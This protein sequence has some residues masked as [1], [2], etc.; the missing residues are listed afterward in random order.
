MKSIYRIISFVTNLGIAENTSPYEARRL[1][2]INWINFSLILLCLVI[3]LLYVSNILPIKSYSFYREALLIICAA[4]SMLCNRFQ[5]NKISKLLTAVYFGFFTLIFPLLFGIVDKESFFWFPFGAIIFSILPY[6]IFK[7][8]AELTSFLITI[9][10]YFL[11]TMYIDRLMISAAGG[12]LNMS[13]L[14]DDYMMYKAPHIFFWGFLNVALLV[15]TFAYDYTE[16]KLQNAYTLLEERSL[17]IKEQADEIGAQNEELIAQSDH[18]RETN[19]NLEKRVEER[20]KKLVEQNKMLSEYAFINAHLLR[21]PL[22]SVLGLIYLLSLINDEEERKEII[23]RLNDS[24]QKLDDV[25]KKIGEVLE[26]GSKLSRED[27]KEIRKE[28]LED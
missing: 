11:L 21:S 4:S 24:A 12:D 15:L 16:K 18:I 3:F 8:K 25:V 6:F 17:L 10:F 23:E 20:T 27:F 5:W 13:F 9:I 1:I 22:S 26:K 2:L 28:V 19:S 7:P 14:P